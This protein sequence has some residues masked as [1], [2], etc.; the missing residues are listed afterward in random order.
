MAASRE[1]R[2][3]LVGQLAR[4][5]PR[6]RG[7][8]VSV[9]GHVSVWPVRSDRWKTAQRRRSVPEHQRD[10]GRADGRNASANTAAERALGGADG[11]TVAAGASGTAVHDASV[12]PASGHDLG[13][14]ADSAA[15]MHVER[16]TSR[17]RRKS[18]GVRQ[19]E[20]RKLS[21]MSTWLLRMVG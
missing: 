11:G 19:K 14:S 5:L 12:P 17:R 6:G 15:D 7:F 3:K 4:E 1:E 2:V 18:D 21:R 13:A 9:D 20:R 10:D 16:A 8:D